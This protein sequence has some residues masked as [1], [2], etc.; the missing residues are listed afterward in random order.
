LTPIPSLPPVVKLTTPDNG[1][2]IILREN[3]SAPVVD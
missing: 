2:F 1:R 3:H